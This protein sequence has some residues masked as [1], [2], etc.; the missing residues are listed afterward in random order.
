MWISGLEASSLVGKLDRHREDI[1][2]GVRIDPRPGR[3]A[4]AMRRREVPPAAGVVEILMPSKSK[5]KASLRLPA[6]TV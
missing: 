2:F 6:K 1:G 5:K 4:A 3:L